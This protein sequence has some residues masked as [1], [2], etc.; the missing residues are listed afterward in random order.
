MKPT[1]LV[2]DEFFKR[3][4]SGV[5]HPEC[6]A[7]CDAVLEGLTR[8]GLDK[9]LHRIPPR[10]AT[11]EE[12]LRCHTPDYFRAA[13][14][15]IESGASM[16]RTGDTNVTADSFQAA[17]L[18][19]GSAVAAVEAVAR[20]EVRNAFCL[21][22]PPGHHATSSQ[23][24]GFCVF[25]NVAVAARSAQQSCGIGRVLIV[26]WDLHHGNGTQDIFYADPSVFY[27][28]TH[29]WPLYPGTGARDEIG[30]DEGRGTTLNR[31]FPPGTRGEEVLQSF[32][33]D[34]VPAAEE[35]RPELVLISAGFDS[36]AGDPLGNLRLTDEDFA[37]LTRLLMEIADR[38]A[39]G[40]LVSMLE[41]GYSL[42]GLA[43]A[44]TAHIRTLLEA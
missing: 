4:L 25:N 9:R 1:G 10:P 41:G 20:G 24:M 6:P 21:V 31:P 36:R 32:R 19:A 33:D 2:Y 15:D 44:A 40:R 5:E 8:A 7:R 26:D 43:S 18:A 35:F 3:H 27:F 34:L 30:W 38:S 17:L 16:L 28:S 12:I 29:Q 13:R 39:K 14:E 42:R 11:E 37:E 23:G 22:R